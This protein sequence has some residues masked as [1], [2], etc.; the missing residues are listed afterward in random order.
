MRQLAWNLICFFPDLYYYFFLPPNVAQIKE[1]PSA[2]AFQK[3]I[4]DYPPFQGWGLFSFHIPGF[5]GEQ[6]NIF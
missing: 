2:R 5:T 3:L 4:K 1:P 6:V